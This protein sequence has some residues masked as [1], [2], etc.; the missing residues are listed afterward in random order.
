MLSSESYDSLQHFVE[1]LLC[2][3]HLERKVAHLAQNHLRFSLIQLIDDL[4]I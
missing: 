2:R 1:N 4:V 3:V